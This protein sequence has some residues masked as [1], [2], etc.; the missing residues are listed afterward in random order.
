MNTKLMKYFVLLLLTFVGLVLW[1]AWSNFAQ[2]TSQ[3]NCLPRGFA[4]QWS[5]TDFC[6]SSVNLD[7]II[8]GGPPKDGIPAITDPVMESVKA[9]STW[10]V[11]QSPVIVVEIEGEARAY[12]QALLIWHEIAND[13]VADVPVAITF[14]PLCNS[15]I[16]FDRRVNDTVLEFGVSGV[17][18]NSD[19]VMFDRQTESWWQQFTGEGIVGTYNGTILEILPSQVLGF[20]QFAERYPDGLVM[21][22][23]TGYGRSYGTNPYTNYDQ[24]SS[25]FLFSGEIDPRLPATERVLAGTLDGVSMAYPFSML[26]EQIV[27]ND[28]LAETPVVVFWQP[29]V[30]SSLDRSSIDESRDIGTAALYERR[31]EDGRVLEFVW[32]SDTQALTDLQTGSQWNLFGEAIQGELT[33]TELRQGLLAPHFWFAWAA[34]QPDTAIYTHE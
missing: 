3:D 30:A 9:A 10:L 4:S 27:I 25:P 32:N 24:S 6:N 8:S 1:S 26:T 13:V 34:F 28:I 7:E 2:D 31:L 20:G 33:G 21:S 18:R 29:G 5:N 15:S 12:P 17:L 11:E 19:M 14:C 16:V 22:R 23:D